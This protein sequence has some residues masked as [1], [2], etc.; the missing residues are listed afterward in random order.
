VFLDKDRTMDNIQK[1]NI[2]TNAPSSQ[3]F[4][5]KK[6]GFENRTW[7]SSLLVLSITEA[8]SVG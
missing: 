4:R 2:S 1:D 6:Y 8:V 7:L 5:K 3:T